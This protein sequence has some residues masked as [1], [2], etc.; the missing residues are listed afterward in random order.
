ML[1]YA[2]DLFLFITLLV[3]LIILF[4]CYWHLCLDHGPSFSFLFVFCILFFGWDILHM[5]AHHMVDFL[6]VLRSVFFVGSDLISRSF[7][8]FL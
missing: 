7:L 5:A 4:L 1:V 2:I 6:W 8:G 3:Y